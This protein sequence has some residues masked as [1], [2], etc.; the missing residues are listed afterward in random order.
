MMIFQWERD[1]KALVNFECGCGQGWSGIIE[2]GSILSCQCGKNFIA[3][4]S[5]MV[6]IHYS[7]KRNQ[8]DTN[9]QI[10]ISELF[11]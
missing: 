10:R 5:G 3:H 1:G 8:I 7:P 2:D 9:K 4:W 11:G 6:V